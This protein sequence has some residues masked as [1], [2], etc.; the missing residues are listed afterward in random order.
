[1]SWLQ[2][3]EYETELLADV[4]E[5]QPEVVALAAVVALTPRV[6]PLLLR[7]A[8]LEFAPGLEAETEFRLWFSP[9]IHARSSADFVLRHGVARLLAN[10]LLGQDEP[11]CEA[12]WDFTRRHTRHWPP[13]ARLERDLRYFVL[14]GEKDNL[15]V[16]LREVLKRIHD[17]RDEAA[18]LD[19]ARW[20]KKNLPVIVGAGHAP[21]EAR[22]LAHYAAQSLGATARWTELS[23]PEPLPGWLSKALP[24]PFETAEIGLDLRHD[25]DTGRRVLACV[26]P[27]D[28]AIRLPLPTP[29]P[30]KLH[31]D[32]GGQAGGWRNVAIGSHIELEPACGDRIVLTTI[33]GARF[34]LNAE[35]PPQVEIPADAAKAPPP[36]LYLSHVA[37]D[38][39]RAGQIAAWLKEHGIEVTLVEERPGEPA[40]TGGEQARLL[41]LWTAAAQRHWAEVEAEPEPPRLPSALLRVEE[42]ALP[43]GIDA[44]EQLFDLIGWQGGEDTPAAQ[45]WLRQLNDWLAGQSIET[46][47]RPGELP[48]FSEEIE[49]LLDELADPNT[50]PPRRLAIGDR[51][52]EL[53]DPRPGVGVVEIEAPAE[54]AQESAQEDNI[55]SLLGEIV[56]PKTEPPRRLAIGDRLAELGD[57]RPGVGLDANGLPDIDW[58]EI[59]GGPFIYQDGEKLELPTFHISRFPITNAQYQAFIDAGGYEK[60]GGVK[61]SSWWKGLKKPEPEASYWPQANR[62]RTD[63]DWYEAVAFTRWLGAQLG[64]EIR[65]PTEQQWEKAAR[66]A[67]G[68]QYPWGNEYRSGYANVDETETKDGP[69]YLEQT[70]AVGLYPQG[71]SPWGVLDMAGNVWEWCLNKH[72]HPEVTA[73]DSSGDS[74]VVRGGSWLGNPDLARA[75]LRGWP[76]PDLRD[77]RRGFRVVLLSAPITDR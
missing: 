69:W 56:E 44:A 73:A 47:E 68:L 55:E 10:E 40:A 9:L 35:T 48:K 49:A 4:R 29:L 54:P 45:R 31:I 51:L 77:N 2:P 60:S 25:P 50:E 7:N 46:E 22:L 66:G 16:G 38:A 11:P 12:V 17:E 70:T 61:R 52:A 59:P 21:E 28:S 1:M 14:R 72:K 33:D 42:V 34:E 18:R 20:A 43:S 24:E 63:V 64:R 41:R 32:C 76:Y 8:R 15:K 6:E 75:S 62:P 58:V 3:S 26:A 36:R 13:L 37:E 65:L 19:L 39:R 53:G 23:E 27:D 5:R 74:R 67:E 30:A 71:Q 57:P